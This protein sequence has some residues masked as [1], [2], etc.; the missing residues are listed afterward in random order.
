MKKLI[1]QDILKMVLAEYKCRC[2]DTKRKRTTDRYALCKNKEGFFYIKIDERELE[3]I[4][5]KNKIWFVYESMVKKQ[6]KNK[7]LF[8]PLTELRE[9]VNK[10]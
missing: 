1:I 7:R 9:Y 10:L 4:S 3:G 5:D 2:L 8:N 6:L